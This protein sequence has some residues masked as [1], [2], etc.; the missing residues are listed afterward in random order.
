MNKVSLLYF[1]LLF[2]SVMFSSFLNMSPFLLEP[3]ARYFFIFILLGT[4]GASSFHPG[5]FHQLCKILAILSS[6]IPFAPFSIPSGIS[7]IY[8]RYF[9]YVPQCL[10]SP[11][12]YFSFFVLFGSLD[13]FPLFPFFSFLVFIAVTGPTRAVV[14]H[15]VPSRRDPAVTTGLLQRQTSSCHPR[16]SVMV[17]I[18]KQFVCALIF[19]RWS[20]GSLS[21]SSSVFNQLS[22][23]P[24]EFL[25]FS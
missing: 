18:S 1:N 2:L 25:I 13:F 23:P 5:L 17:C 19:V 21:L 6:A 14:A 12:L 4:L 24:M 11:F 15:R 8:V 22:N 20:S 9:H 10:R 3:P 16:P 7:I